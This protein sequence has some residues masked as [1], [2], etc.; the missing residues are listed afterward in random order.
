[1]ST[2]LSKVLQI[3]VVI[4][5][6]VSGLLITSC[7]RKNDANKKI[8]FAAI[9]TLTGP[10]AYLGEDEKFGIQTALE[11]AGG[12]AAPISFVFE[13]C[14]G[15]ADV[16]VTAA[17][18][19]MD[20]SKRQFFAVFTTT[21]V[22]A[23]LPMFKDSGKD[24]FVVAQC[25]LPK[26]TVGYPFAYRTYANSD[27]E[28]DLL[29]QYAVEK[30]FK[31]VAGLHMSNRFGEEGVKTFKSKF[32]LADNVVPK[33]ES[34][35]F[36]DKDFRGVLEKLRS[37]QPDALIIYA[38]STT[39]PIIFR[40]MQEMGWTIPVLAN[41]DMALGGI[42]ESV[43]NDFLKNVVFPA[44]RYYFSPYDPKIIAFNKL[45][46]EKG[47]E[48]NFDIGYSYDMTK[49]LIA[50]ARKAKDNTPSSFAEAVRTVMP[51]DGVTGRITLDKNRDTRAD[52]K[53]V[54]WAES[55]I[56]IVW[57]TK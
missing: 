30:K 20:F 57:E 6:V 16:A 49:I 25:M 44:P 32:E 11:S 21:P 14:Q 26:V 53:L 40:Q 3:T 28:T 7:A 55:G 56:E 43:P 13:D 9:L 46:R 38:Y 41:C 29:S 10:T 52:M 33:I 2:K 19:Q 45:I 1:M 4:V 12:D 18:K 22:L 24:L 36:A 37:T 15:K 42:K 35:S 23:T 51:F 34:F 17:R 8:E 31:R 47:R 39:F 5:T 50:A 48:P 27:E 54:H